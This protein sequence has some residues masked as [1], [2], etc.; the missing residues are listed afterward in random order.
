MLNTYCADLTFLITPEI[1]PFAPSEPINRVGLRIPCNLYLADPEFHKPGE[2]DA[3]IGAEIFLQLLCNGQISLV[4]NNAIL[5]KT[6]LGWILGGKTSE[7]TFPS[8]ARCNL[9]LNLLNRNIEKFWELE[10]CPQASRLSKEEIAC[11]D[12]YQKNTYRDQYSGKYCV[13]LPFKENEPVLGESYSNALK[14]LYA[15]ERSFIKKPN[16]KE[17]YIENLKSYI[18]NDH[19]SEGNSESINFG[20]FLA[21]HAV[22]KQS[23]LTT[24]VRVVFDASAKTSNGKSLND[25]L[26]VGPNIQEKLFPL[27]IRFRS[28]AYALT[29]DIEKMFRQIQVHLDDQKFLKILWRETTD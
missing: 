12:H 6:K 9:S 21:H 19:M 2:I 10:H 7:A 11:E 13:K 1:N 8:V 15:T 29:T 25:T 14:R 26:M 18:E 28:H 4:S 27:L 23:S 24:K 22:I 16:L 17:P 20:Y 5:Q 3:L